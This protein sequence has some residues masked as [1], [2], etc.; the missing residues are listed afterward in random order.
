MKM[1]FNN[2]NDNPDNLDPNSPEFFASNQKPELHYQAGDIV[3]I[4][5]TQYTHGKDES[6]LGWTHDSGQWIDDSCSTNDGRMK[7]IRAD[8]AG[9][10]LGYLSDQDW[11]LIDEFSDGQCHLRPNGGGVK[12]M[13]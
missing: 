6:N 11:A 13:I 10:E 12:W 7:I 8:S 1:K 2:V 5:S 3:H 9:I 4:Y